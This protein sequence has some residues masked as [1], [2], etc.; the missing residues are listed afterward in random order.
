M[1]LFFDSNRVEKPIDRWRDS[2]I[3][4]SS[5]DFPRIS[6]ELGVGERK[7]IH[8]FGMTSSKKFSEPRK[9]FSLSR[10]ENT[11]SSL[12]FFPAKDFFL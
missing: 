1:T 7:Q 9:I 11:F 6:K 3:S 10:T 12:D 8:S 2:I 5:I 4:S